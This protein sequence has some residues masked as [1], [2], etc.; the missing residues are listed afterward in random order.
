MKKKKDMYLTALEYGEKSLNEGWPVTFNTLK[1]HL[2]G[3][4]F[5]F[6]TEEKERLLKDLSRESFHI[7]IEDGEK[8]K[9]APHYINTEGY[10]K[11]LDYRE[12]KEARSSS[13]EA[14][15]YAIIAIVISIITLFVSIYFS[16]KAL[17]QDIKLDSN[18]FKVIE[19]AIEKLK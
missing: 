11:L 19:E 5:I 9:D 8:W 16:N 7:Y 6:E 13:K 4:G 18:Q 3:H 1:K 14:R 15:Y 12:L 17:N 2:E 10:F